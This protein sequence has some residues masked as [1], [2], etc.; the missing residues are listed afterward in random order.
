MVLAVL[1]IQLIQ[2]SQPLQFKFL[3]LKP[4]ILL[5]KLGDDVLHL[6]VIFQSVFQFCIIHDLIVNSGAHPVHSGLYRDQKI[7]DSG[8]QR[9]QPLVMD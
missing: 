8:S 6:L 2:L 9:R 5:R 3:R 1:L 7:T 4:C